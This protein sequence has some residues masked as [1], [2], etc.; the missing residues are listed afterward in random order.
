MTK[1][2]SIAVIAL[3]LIMFSG[4]EIVDTSP[5]NTAADNTDLEDSETLPNWIGRFG[6]ETNSSATPLGGFLL[7]GGGGTAPGSYPWLKDQAGGGDLVA[8][9]FDTKFPQDSSWINARLSDGFNSVTI[10]VAN[11]RDRANH[12]STYEHLK[13][14]EAV[15]LDGGDQTAY[16]N[17]WKGTK[18]ETAL[19]YLIQVRGTPIAGT[20][21]GMHTLG[22]YAY[23]PSGSAIPS[24]TTITNL[25]DSRMSEV[26]ASFLRPYLP[27]WLGSV[28]TDT[29]FGK[30]NR[31]S[32]FIAFAAKLKLDGVPDVGGIACDEYTAVAIDAEGNARVF[33]DSGD[34]DYAYFIRSQ[35]GGITA[36]PF[37]WTSGVSVYRVRGLPGGNNTFSLTDWTG[38]GGVNKG[39]YRVNSGQISINESG[40][41]NT[42][43][44]TLY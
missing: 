36:N 30:R 23:L 11:S 27:D 25:N 37:F 13:N 18:V 2:K 32:R 14:A 16:Y 4:C 35:G 39:I 10:I 24:D 8:L 40:S 29:H 1:F 7:I 38:S 41:H 6:S 34:D 19:E 21:A 3:L 33:G 9:S 31:M 5:D 26:K 44:T 15:F 17:T 28:V 43:S 20:S 22:G 42:T 12:E